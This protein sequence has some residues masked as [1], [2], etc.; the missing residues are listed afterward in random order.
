MG[1][2]NP[3]STPPLP[4]PRTISPVLTSVTP[5]TN[6]FRKGPVHT[7]ERAR[8][9]VNVELPQIAS[10]TNSFGQEQMQSLRRNKNASPPQVT[11]PGNSGAR[12]FH[13]RIQELERII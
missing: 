11:L 7:A 6:P 5:C 12:S 4:S 2:S 10:G 13:A 8:A 9:S 1:S 3:F